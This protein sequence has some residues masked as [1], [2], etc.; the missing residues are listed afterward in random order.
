MKEKE[1][2]EILESLILGGII[3]A[4]LGTLLS[5]EKGTVIG[6]VAGAAVLA[7]YK[8][9]LK[10]KKTNLPV[11]VMEDGVIYSVTSKGKRKLIKKIEK[12]TIKTRNILNSNNMSQKRM[13]VFAGPNGSGKTI[14]L[15]SLSGEISFGVY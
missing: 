12:Q 2:D 3:G 15:K 10:A 1:D 13:R 9:N 6:A 7:S 5:K 4:G 14:I 8:A 11:F